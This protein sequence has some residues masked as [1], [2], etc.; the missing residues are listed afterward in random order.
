MH[1]VKYGHWQEGVWWLGCLG[2]YPDD[3]TQGE[4]L[5]DL[6]KHLN[7]P[8]INSWPIPLASLKLD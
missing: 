2:E 7:N 3:W 1:A 5:P 6:V 8:A 4:T